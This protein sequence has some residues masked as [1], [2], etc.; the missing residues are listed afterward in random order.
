MWFFEI[1]E[2]ERVV[3]WEEKIFF[4]TLWEVCGFVKCIVERDEKFNHVKKGVC[5]L[6]LFQAWSLNEFYTK[7][8]LDSSRGGS[9]LA[10]EE[11]LLVYSVGKRGSNPLFHTSSFPSFSVSPLS[12]ITSY[13]FIIF[14]IEIEIIYFHLKTW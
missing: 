11:E 10:I 1:W 5:I 7:I 13:S 4:V 2:G 9:I 6:F 8:L 3:W 14:Q 12:K